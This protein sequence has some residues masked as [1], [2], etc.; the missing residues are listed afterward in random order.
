MKAQIEAW[1][2]AVD[3]K[4]DN[5]HW[6]IDVEY[7]NYAATLTINR[8][9]YSERGVE[10]IIDPYIIDSKEGHF[11]IDATWELIFEQMD[12]CWPAV[13]ALAVGWDGS[14]LTFLNCRLNSVEDVCCNAV[15]TPTD[16]I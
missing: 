5:E 11:D 16:W 15:N 14:H 3:E 9:V 12:R 7:D 4:V 10:T 1:Y 2:N 13:F 6:I 8:R